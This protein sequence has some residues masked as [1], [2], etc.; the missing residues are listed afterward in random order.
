MTQRNAHS[1]YGYLY[2]DNH[3]GRLSRL[4]L[5]VYPSRC[6]FSAIIESGA[7]FLYYRTLVAQRQ[8]VITAP[9]ENTTHLVVCIKRAKGKITRSTKK[10]S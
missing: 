4:G 1:T 7:F 9:R 10:K 3:D 8:G 6:L 5:F 2:S